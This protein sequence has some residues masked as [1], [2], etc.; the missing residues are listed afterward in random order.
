L[1]PAIHSLEQ[2][3]QGT[4]LSSIRPTEKLSLSDRLLDPGSGGARGESEGPGRRW[5]AA[6]G[7]W[8][9]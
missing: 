4:S 8:Y 3:K 9:G 5:P 6:C 7:A 2:L 1:P